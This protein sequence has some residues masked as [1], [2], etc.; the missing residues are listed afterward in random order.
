MTTQINEATKIQIA[1]E[2]LKMD[3]TEKTKKQI[4][5]EFSVST[6]SVSRYADKYEEEALDLINTPE[7]V[8]LKDAFEVPAVTDDDEEEE[9]ED[10]VEAKPELKGEEIKPGPR[11][12]KKRNGRWELLNAVFAEYGLDTKSAELY[13]IVNERSVEKGLAPLAKGSFYAMVSIARKS[14]K[15]NEE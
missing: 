12:G 9:K 4:A 13:K 1:V 6:R 14:A 11:G 7:A 5:D 2:V 10:A 8:E 3:E 15:N